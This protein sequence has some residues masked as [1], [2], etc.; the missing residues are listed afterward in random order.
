MQYT[1]GIMATAKNSHAKKPLKAANAKVVKKPA[2][3]VAAKKTAAKKPASNKVDYYPN[4]MTF[5][6]SAAAGSIIV[7]IAL[8][9]VYNR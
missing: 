4:R 3:K 7:L 2:K 1:K 6:V 5:W 8:I 9:C